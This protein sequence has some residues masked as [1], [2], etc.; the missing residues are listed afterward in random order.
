MADF[1]DLQKFSSDFSPTFIQA[2]LHAHRL[3]VSGCFKE[4][5]YQ[6]QLK[7]PAAFYEQESGPHNPPEPHSPEQ[8]ADIM[9]DPVPE[10]AYLNECLSKWELLH[11]YNN[12]KRSLPADQSG[13]PSCLYDYL[14]GLNYIIDNVEKKLVQNER[15]VHE[16]LDQLPSFT[17]LQYQNSKLKKVIL[18][19]LCERAI[20]FYHDPSLEGFFIGEDFQ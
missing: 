15:E 6:L 20:R 18:S 17:L 10:T 2:L 19:A 16:F 5:E 7:N 8:S 3:D 4:L 12:L 1:L 11:L 9:P 13:Y 14:S